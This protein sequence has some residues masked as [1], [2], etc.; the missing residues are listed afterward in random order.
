[1]PLTKEQRQTLLARASSLRE[2]IERG[3]TAASTP[4]DKA[5][6]SARRDRWCK[7]ASKGDFAA[8]ESMLV[9]RNIE[10]TELD[11]ILSSPLY[12]DDTLATNW[13]ESIDAVLVEAA[14]TEATSVLP[15]A[16]DVPFAEFYVPFCAVA[17]KGLVLALTAGTCTLPDTVH[18]AISG[19]LARSLHFV[20]QS[21][22]A[23]ERRIANIAHGTQTGDD[24]ESRF[25]NAL[26][27]PQ[28]LTRF[29]QEYSVAA[30]AASTLMERW[31]HN[32]LEW[33]RRLANDTE[34]I[35]SI[36]LAGA[37]LGKLCQIEGNLS[38]PHQG[39][40]SV[41]RLHFTSGLR[42]IYKPRSVALDLAYNNLLDWLDNHGAPYPLRKPVYLARAEYA[43]VEQID[44]SPCRSQDE[45]LHFCNAAGALLCVSYLL[46]AT[47]LHDSNLIATPECPVIVDL[48]TLLQPRLAAQDAS[49]KQDALR[50]AAMLTDDSVLRTGLLPSLKAGADGTVADVGCLGGL[51]GA[52]STAWYRHERSA[53]PLSDAMLSAMTSGALDP[54]V[55][56]E[57]VTHGFAQTYRFVIGKRDALLDGEG[58]L[59]HFNNRI[60]RFLLRDTTVYIKLLES[61]FSAHALREGVDR[62][63]VLEALYR[64]AQTRPD[65]DALA[66]VVE[67]EIAA[68][69]A[70]DVP[71]ISATTHSTGLHP[72]LGAS[73]PRLFEQATYPAM[74][75]RLH[76]FGE[77]DLTRQL[78]YVRGAFAARMANMPTTRS[79]NP[80]AGK[81]TE[82]PRSASDGLAM[83]RAFANELQ[84]KAI[85][86]DDGSV[87]W[88]APVP[89]AGTGH[90][91]F[92]M[93]PLNREFGILGVA[94]FLAAY[95]RTTGDTAAGA[96]A[97]RAVQTVVQRLELQRDSSPTGTGSTLYSLQRI[98]DFLNAPE[99]E[100]AAHRLVQRLPDI[101]GALSQGPWSAADRSQLCLGLLAIRK[102]EL[103]IA[104]GQQLFQHWNQLERPQRRATVLTAPSLA[105]C[106][107]RL[108]VAASAEHFELASR[109]T[110]E[111]LREASEHDATQAVN[112]H[113]ALLDCV[114]QQPDQWLDNWLSDPFASRRHDGSSVS[115][116]LL[117]GT[118][119]VAERLVTASRKLHRPELHGAAKRLLDDMVRQAVLAGGYQTVPGLPRGAFF[120]G[121]S[122]GLS[123]IGY[124]LLRGQADSNLPCVQLW[125]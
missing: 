84:Q 73:E 105:L 109:E 9:R 96:L 2:R 91:R 81:S 114:D 40:R 116:N 72:H 26:R 63:I 67:A 57:K 20:F 23:L 119:S 102:T 66:A 118:C 47:D 18:R 88:M 110:M 13:T 85:T 80:S 61:S 32:T 112:L 69:E 97:I 42:L 89:I 90:F 78:D 60:V 21:A 36:F 59:K 104:W 35:T 62:S 31:Q 33:V 86:G 10:P 103:G 22:L 77:A 41:M 111:M 30:R 106:W 98:A 124:T 24:S 29:L 51:F 48:E 74:L 37:P 115:D 56:V 76:A 45:L 50:K 64:T 79:P 54:T 99:I 65:S 34:A 100:A 46:N 43:W 82:E 101:K 4:T 58:P 125:D 92:D 95:C 39:G 117:H 16:S 15:D 7:A 108:S 12:A 52:V 75:Q 121:F 113:F 11:Q 25:A 70:L 49:Q 87:T 6:A 28:N 83:V 120:P 38:D 27:Q 44:H 3:S 5:L 71:L 68:L 123:G 122:Q 55:M 107:H 53:S 8:F 17:H 94:F 1:M 14:R 93:L 19:S